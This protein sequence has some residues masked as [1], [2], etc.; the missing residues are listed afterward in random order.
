ML[1]KHPLVL[2]CCSLAVASVAAAAPVI[3]Q[4]HVI[5]QSTGGRFIF[6]GNSPAQTFTAGASGLLSQVDVKLRRDAGDIGDLSLEIWPVVAEG[7]AG[8]IPLLSTSIDPNAVT[9]G[10]YDFVDVDVS[11]EGL[12]VSAG[13]QYAITVS[14][15][16]ELGGPIA[17]WQS[18]RPGYAAGNLF[19]RSGSWRYQTS[20]FDY[21][22][23]T[24]VDPTGAGGLNEVMIPLIEDAEAQIYPNIGITSYDGNTIIVDAERTDGADS[25]G[26]FTF[27]ASMLPE[28]ADIQSAAFVFDMN[29]FTS[30]SGGNPVV[31]VYGFAGSG[32]PTAGEASDLSRQLGSTGPIT[33]LEV[34]SV[35]L[36]VDEI[37]SL[38]TQTDTIGLTAYQ[39]GPPQWVSI[40]SSEFAQQFPSSF[41][42]PQLK[43]GLAPQPVQP[44][45]PDGDYNR[46]AHVDAADYTVWRDNQGDSAGYADWSAN[47]GT[48][49]DTEVTDGDF[50]SGDLSE[51]D[52]TIEA[53]TSVPFG[54]PR[55][56]TFDVD[57]DGQSDEAFRVRLG[58]SD[59]DQFGGT[60]TIEQ[61]I[62]LGEGD[63]VFSADVASQSLE[64]T[65]GN[66]G[67]GNYELMI[68]GVIVD[69]VLQDGNLISAGE[70]IRDRLEATLT[71]L[72]PG[73]HTLTL[74]VNR[75]A[76]TF[77]QI[78]HFIDN[79]S[80]EA[81]GT[82]RA[83][84]EPSVLMLMAVAS[85]AMLLRRV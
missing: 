45:V 29:S 47:Y 50:S 30:G 2:A 28:G 3:D 81:V 62:L 74:T 64:S 38:L 34:Q 22:F 72:Q 18:G 23:R 35:A 68:D 60:V 44:D 53:N 32:L 80:F 24:W 70:V 78:Y 33:E 46:D 19:S 13:E 8:S 31:E 58:R 15:T 43:L 10:T 71:D 59:T 16:A 27:D 51:W 20:D 7:P 42:A 37:K 69:Q 40:V 57:G 61:E 77:A 49:P 41:E 66:T 52:V 21:G 75:G 85:S 1:S 4:S 54:F 39:A 84:P 55:V 76:T 83:V 56:E 25:R 82:S 11:A 14:G 12:L 17:A 5:T 79:I 36:D 63:Y 26:L 67:P 65:A 48:A 73:Y 6:G 9:V